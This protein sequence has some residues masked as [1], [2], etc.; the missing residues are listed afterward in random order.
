MS[1]VEI[2]K[3]IETEIRQQRKDEQK[4]INEITTTTNLEFAQKAAS[5]LNP[6]KHL[7]SFEGYLSLLQMLLTALLAGIPPNEALDAVQTGW[8]IEKILEIWKYTQKNGSQ[9]Y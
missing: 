8:E 1:M 2:V 7:Y 5:I 3:Q 4:L 9:N 6:K